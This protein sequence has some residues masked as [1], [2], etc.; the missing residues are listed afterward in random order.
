MFSKQILRRSWRNRFSEANNNNTLSFDQTDL[1]WEPFGDEDYEVYYTPDCKGHTFTQGGLVKNATKW[2]SETF[3]PVNSLYQDQENVLPLTKTQ[4]P[5]YY[6]Q[7][8]SRGPP[9]TDSTDIS[10]PSVSKPIPYP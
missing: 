10:K 9:F 3:V 4:D 8:L 1:Q 7:D 6:Q 2:Y 5:Y